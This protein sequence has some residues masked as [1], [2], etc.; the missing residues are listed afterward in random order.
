[1]DLCNKAVL[2]TYDLDNGNT[3]VNYLPPSEIGVCPTE[4]LEVMH[5]PYVKTTSIE[6]LFELEKKNVQ[7]QSSKEVIFD[8]LKKSQNEIIYSYSQVKNRIPFTALVRAFISDEGYY[9]ISYKNGVAGDLKKEEILQ[10]KTRL[11]MIK[12]TSPY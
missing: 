10:W 7:K 5:I 4:C 8:V 12:K 2:H 3:L 11:E 6:G 1:M 9:S